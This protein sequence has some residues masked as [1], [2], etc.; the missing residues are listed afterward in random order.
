MVFEKRVPGDR[1]RDRFRVFL[2]SIYQG[3]I[4]FFFI[5]KFSLII[6]LINMGNTCG[7]GAQDEQELN[8]PSKKSH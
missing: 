5:Y 4:M 7:C 2:S 8:L 1:F 3:V 6:Q